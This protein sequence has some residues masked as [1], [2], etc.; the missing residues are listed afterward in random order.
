MV[1]VR[2]YFLVV[3]AILLIFACRYQG[4]EWH[5]ISDGSYVQK[6]RFHHGQLVEGVRCWDRGGSFDCVRMQR[7]KPPTILLNRYQVSSLNSTNT[8]GGHFGCL[9]E[10]SS[11]EW[12]RQ[13]ISNS[14]IRGVN[15]AA[16]TKSVPRLGRKNEWTK[17][18][19]V[20]VLKKIGGS[21][22]DYL[23][24]RS[25]SEIIVINGSERFLETKDL[26]LIIN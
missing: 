22:E 4:G 26:Q 21:G 23:N 2:N 13:I 9:L 19:A 16:F 15:D 8:I 6:Y 24:C 25:A 18:Q 5:Q 12:F 20:L 14:F 3:S 1:R 11:S 7:L 10:P 17:K